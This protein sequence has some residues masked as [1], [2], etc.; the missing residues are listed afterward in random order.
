MSP[1]LP[2]GRGILD[3]STGD[4]HGSKVQDCVIVLSRGR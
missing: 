4:E 1:N 2:F 3:V